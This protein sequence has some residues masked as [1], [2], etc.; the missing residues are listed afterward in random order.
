ME[1][2]KAG[3]A[4]GLGLRAESIRRGPLFALTADCQ[5]VTD[6]HHHGCQGEGG[7]EKDSGPCRL[8][9]QADHARNEEQDLGHDVGG[10]DGP[11]ESAFLHD[12]G[13]KEELACTTLML[14]CLVGDTSPPELISSVQL[15]LGPAVDCQF[16]EDAQQRDPD[17]DGGRHQAGHQL[18]VHF[19]APFGFD[20]PLGAAQPDNL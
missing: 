19:G 14:G 16:G 17:G 1:S 8:V 20:A 13:A 4:V 18:F 11:K 2:G 6:N 12:N 3:P 10:R 5:T 7:G 15:S 9:A